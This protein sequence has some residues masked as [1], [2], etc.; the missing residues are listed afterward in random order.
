M[1]SSK[2]AQRQAKEWFRACLVD[3]R[4]ADERVRV[5]VGRVIEARPRG[6]RAGLDHFQRL[7]RIAVARRTARVETAV[8]L[9]PAV[10]R[11][12]ESRLQALYGGGLEISFVLDPALIG[13]MRVRV[14]SDVLDGSVRGRLAAL[15]DC[16]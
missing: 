1:K 13:G 7:V 2:Q 9:E 6:Y 12:I 3:G 16:W 10:A 5:T 8:A 14:G 15:G 11:S 4:L